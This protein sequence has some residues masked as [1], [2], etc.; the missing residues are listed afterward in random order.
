MNEQEV[1][2]LMQWIPETGT[3]TAPE[4][5]RIIRPG[6]RPDYQR[7]FASIKLRK[8][9]DRGLLTKVCEAKGKTT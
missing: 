8:L 9:A 6:S 4:F 1:A 5:G 7:T 2:E 3:I